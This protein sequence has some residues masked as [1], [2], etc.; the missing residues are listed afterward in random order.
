MKLRGSAVICLLFS[1]MTW[2]FAQDSSLHMAVMSGDRDQVQVMISA[3]ADVNAKMTRGW[4]P[5]M[6]AA[7]YGNTE[8]MSLLIQNRANINLT[9]DEGNT[10]LMMAVTGRRLAAVRL[11]LNNR[12]DRRIKNSSGLD[13]VNIAKLSGF[14][15]AMKLLAP[16]GEQNNT[17]QASTLSDGKI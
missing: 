4:T 17:L 7:K 3:G 13:A 8:I 15:E 5:L 11:L 12:A 2:I 16:V 6:V 9:D 10:A 14:E 1:S